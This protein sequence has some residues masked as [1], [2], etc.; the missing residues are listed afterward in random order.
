MIVNV[1]TLISMSDFRGLTEAELTRKLKAIE[2]AIRAYTN[3][4]F[5]NRNVRFTAKT[6]S[7][8]V[9]G[10]SPFLRVGDTIQISKSCVNDGIYTI[11][12]ISKKGFIRLDTNKLFA[13][14]DNLITKVEY[15]VDI[16][17]G[18][19]NL[20]KWEVENREKVGI[21]SETLSRHTV[22]YFDQDKDN[23]VMGYP[24]ALLGFLQ[25]YMKARF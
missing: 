22:S 2:L 24:V 5:Q 13:V 14:E 20:M 25:P 11:T 15:P 16:V 9:Y 7:D 23:T 19:I 4:N 12:E 17:Q 3:N 21:K 8:K 1:E 10:T 18:V 6:Y